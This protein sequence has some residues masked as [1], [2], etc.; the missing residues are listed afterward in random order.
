VRRWVAEF[1][2]LDYPR[3]I[4]D[5]LAERRVALDRYREAVAG[6]PGAVPE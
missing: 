3:P 5:H 1:D 4:V 6:E 2:S